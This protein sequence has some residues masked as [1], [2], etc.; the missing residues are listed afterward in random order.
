MAPLSKLAISSLFIGRK[1]MTSSYCLLKMKT[2]NCYCLPNQ[3]KFFQIGI[4]THGS[5]I[6]IGDI[7]LIY[8][9]EDH[10]EQ[11]LPAQDEDSELLLPTEPEQVLSDRNF[12]PWLHY[13]NW[14]YRAYLSGG[15]P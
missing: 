5:T 11:L 3:S 15:R 7:E 9:E 13:Q 10:D 12:N 1:T 2:P 8:R 14:R 6:K 4:L